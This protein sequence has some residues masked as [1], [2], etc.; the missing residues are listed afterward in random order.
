[1]SLWRSGVTA[2]NIKVKIPTQTPRALYSF[3]AGAIISYKHA[4]EYYSW[5][6]AQAVGPKLECG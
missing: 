2:Q 3:S 6:S 1:M 5:W 4:W